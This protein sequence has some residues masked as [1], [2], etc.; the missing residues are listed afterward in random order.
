MSV[1]FV[2]GAVGLLLMSFVLGVTLDVWIFSAYSVLGSDHLLFSYWWVADVASV[3]LAGLVAIA[4]GLLVVVLLGRG[5][6]ELSLPLILGFNL[7]AVATAT[8]ALSDPVAGL[9]EAFYTSPIFWT[10]QLGCVCGI[11]LGGEP[12]SRV[13]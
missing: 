4:L 6:A 9:I 7:A 11:W 2:A 8:S 3:V 13:V 12:R 1:A 10:F 5:R